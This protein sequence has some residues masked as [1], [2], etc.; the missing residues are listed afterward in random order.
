MAQPS[1]Q[2]TRPGTAFCGARAGCSPLQAGSGR[3]GM[4]AAPQQRAGLAVLAAV[5][6]GHRE[7]CPVTTPA[8]PQ[9]PQGAEPGVPRG[10]PAPGMCQSPPSLQRWETFPVAV[11]CSSECHPMTPQL[12]LVRAEAAA[13][14]SS[15]SHKHPKQLHTD[16]S[17]PPNQCHRDGRQVTSRDLLIPS[18][19]LAAAAP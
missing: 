5:P 13:A 19:V 11:R 17:C 10:C 7:S 8:L 18:A 2:L 4:S 9:P 6:G 12:F 1:T 15:P 16:N 14:F 3:W